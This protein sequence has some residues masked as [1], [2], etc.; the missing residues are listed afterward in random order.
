MS[1]ASALKRFPAV[2]YCGLRNRGDLE[3]ALFSGATAVGFV[4]TPSVR[5]VTM[6]TAAKLV[7]LTPRSLDSVLVIDADKLTFPLAMLQDL[8]ADVVQVHHADPAVITQLSDLGMRLIVAYS[9]EEWQHDGADRE[10]VLLDAVNPG[11]GKAWDWEEHA[12][13]RIE[14]PWIIAGGLTPGTVVEAVRRTRPWGVDVSSGL[15]SSP[16]VKST[17]LMLRFG[18]EIGRLRP[19]DW[20]NDC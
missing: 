3:T 5:Q 13:R 4:L 10:L 6:E 14:R 12:P 8:R 19:A 15:E 9:A 17:K 20:G 2:K 1:A 7:A 16:G 18:H 11:S